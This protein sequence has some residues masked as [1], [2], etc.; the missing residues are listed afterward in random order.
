[1]PRYTLPLDTLRRIAAAYGGTPIETGSGGPLDNFTAVVDPGPG[2]DSTLGYSVGSIWINTVLNT[3]F[4]CAD[5][6]AGAAVWIDL[7]AAGIQGPPGLQGPPGVDG[8]PGEDA[9]FIGPPGPVGGIGATGVAGALGPP[10]LDGAQGEDGLQGSPGVAGIE[11]VAGVAGVLGPPGSDGE[12]GEPGIAG[13]PGVAGVDGRA[14]RDGPP[15]LDGEEGEPGIQGPSGV[16]GVGGACGPMG[17]PGLD[18]EDSESDGGRPPFRALTWQDIPKQPGCKLQANVNQA[19]VTNV[20]TTMPFQVEEWDTDGYHDAGGPNPEYITIP[21]G[22]GG[23]YAVFIECVWELHA[24]SL[25][26]LGMIYLNGGCVSQS[27][28]FSSAAD[29]RSVTNFIYTEMP[30]VPG[31]DVELRGRQRS[32]GNLNMNAGV[33]GCKLGVRYLGPT[34]V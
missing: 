4:A 21:V 1:M 15:G 17:P 18:G 3:V 28:L 7:G 25:Q 14:G 22:L 33:L 34:P 9:M 31:D 12:E 23:L 29:A 2:D 6:S 5:A 8:L 10:G 19:C 27:G 20:I 11:G 16:A 30:L 32:G 26:R 13:P 24:D